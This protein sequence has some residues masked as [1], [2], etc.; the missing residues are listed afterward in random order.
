MRLIS[1]PTLLLAAAI[2]AGT[3][4]ALATPATATDPV[5]RTTIAESYCGSDKGTPSRP[6]RQTPAPAPSPSAPGRR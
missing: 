6:R 2:T 5:Q 3:A 4:A 1:L